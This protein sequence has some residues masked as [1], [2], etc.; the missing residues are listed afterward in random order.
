LTA[1]GP[2]GRVTGERTLNVFAGPA[3]TAPPRVRIKPG[4]LAVAVLAGSDHPAPDAAQCPPP[5]RRLLIAPPGSTH[6]TAVP[7]WIPN[8][9]AYL[10]A[11]T[12]IQVSPVI[13]ASDLPFLPSHH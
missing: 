13:P 2:A 8:F 4:A 1:V 3:L 12:R 10:P 6:H 5:F 9:D 11:C 7:A